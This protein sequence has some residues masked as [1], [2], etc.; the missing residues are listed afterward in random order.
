MKFPVLCCIVAG[1]VSSLL[2]MLILGGA[3]S[4]TSGSTLAEALGVC[5]CF[6]PEG[7][8]SSLPAIPLASISLG[9][10]SFWTS[11]LR[12]NILSPLAG[13]IVLSVAVGGMKVQVNFDHKLHAWPQ[14]P[15]ERASMGQTELRE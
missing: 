2:V 4:G 6:V 9:W 8:D 1:S 13:T 7:W 12:F 10:F 11:S 5:C 14:I 15:R 3:G